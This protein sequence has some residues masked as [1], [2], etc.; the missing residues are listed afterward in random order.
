MLA[1]LLDEQELHEI[2]QQNLHLPPVLLDQEKK[3][4]VECMT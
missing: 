4:H 2:K 1:G 3:V